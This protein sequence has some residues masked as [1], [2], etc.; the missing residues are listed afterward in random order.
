MPTV[1]DVARLAGVST[2]TVSRVMRGSD[3]VRPVTR[4][5]VL[6]VI[7]EVGFVPD[8]SAQGLSRRRKEIIGLVALERGVNE[9]DIERDGLLFVD[10]V[11]HA[12]EA[13]LRGTDTSLLLSFGPSGEQFHNRIRALSGKVDGLLVVE[14]ALGPAQLRALARRLPVVAIAASPGDSG[15]D[16]VRVDNPAGMRAMAGHLTAGHGYR[17]LGFVG[18]PPD[19]PDAVER[20]AAFSSAVR[21]VPGC[22]VDVVPGGDFSEASGHTA[23]RVLLGREAI[24]EAVACANDQMAIGVMRELQRS[25][26][27]VPEDVAVTGFDNIFPGRVV[28]PPLTT[29]AQPVRDLG[30]R[31]AARLMERIEGSTEPPRAETL[32]T[33]LVLR[34]SC[35]CPPGD[36]A[37]DGPLG[38]R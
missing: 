23:A 29:V 27:R 11:V 8:A 15:L 20:L 3:L 25:G 37:P 1:Y 33:E 26:I 18:G 5:R 28:E 13:V 19:A 38:G 2:A 14:D 35:G 6:A 30:V 16:V 10:V 17:R 32:P 21:D 22:T 31:A 36:P 7:E 4:D 24:P 12:V 9:T 34:R